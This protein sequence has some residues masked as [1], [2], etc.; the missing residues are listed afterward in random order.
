MGVDAID[1]NYGAIGRYVSVFSELV[2]SMRGWMVDQLSADP[3]ILAEIPFGDASAR[4]IADAFFAMCE[5]V[6]PDPTKGERDVTAWLKKA[7]TKELNWRN[8]TAHGDWWP[9][10]SR[11][12]GAAHVVRIDP[13][14]GKAN[15]FERV[16]AVTA[17]GLNARS[18][19][20]LRLDRLV[21]EF[22]AVC[23]HHDPYD[24][25]P[26][27]RVGDIFAIR[28]KQVARA[29]VRAN[30]FPPVMFLRTRVFDQSP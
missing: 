28:D 6:T 30:D 1:P 17:R 26:T 18:D 10:T 20:V 22:G 29:G 19:K 23:F 21:N 9:R 2:A 11:D 27:V 24:E 15:K 13:R 7:I 4:V 8:D 25:D 3:P 12:D 14:A 5:A 16:Q